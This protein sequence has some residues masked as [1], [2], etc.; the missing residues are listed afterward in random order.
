VRARKSGLAALRLAFFFFGIALLLYRIK[1]AD[2]S[3]GLKLTPM[4]LV[5]APTVNAKS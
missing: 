3:K 5:P 4:G 2:I 1:D